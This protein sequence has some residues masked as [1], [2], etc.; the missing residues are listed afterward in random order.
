M[1]YCTRTIVTP[2][3][4]RRTFITSQTVEIDG[5]KRRLEILRGGSGTDVEFPALGGGGASALTAVLEGSVYVGF[6]KKTGLQLDAAADE[7]TVVS[8]ICLFGVLHVA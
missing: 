1:P 3:E 4:W 5:M 7:K 6:D 8:R 2:A